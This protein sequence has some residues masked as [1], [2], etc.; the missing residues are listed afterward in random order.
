MR[1][2]QLGRIN[3]RVKRFRRL[4]EADLLL[5]REMRSGAVQHGRD[6]ARFLP[7]SGRP[8]LRNERNEMLISRL[9][10]R[11]SSLLPVL[12]FFFYLATFT[13]M[14]TAITR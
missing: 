12:L 10:G 11:T 6:A 3:G 7:R 14:M 4:L 8:K 9:T 13:T 1:G 5:S 2:C